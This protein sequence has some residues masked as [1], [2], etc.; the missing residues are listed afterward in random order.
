MKIFT[1]LA[2]VTVNPETGKF[3][4]W[5]SEF[6]QGSAQGIIP[7]IIGLL[8]WAV[9]AISVLMII[10]GGLMYTLSAGDPS[11]T[12]KAKDTIL[13]AVIGLVIALA[14]GAIVTFVRGKFL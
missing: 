10:I 3:T 4:S 2:E 8:L 1:K 7:R 14:A 13:F 6:I 12:K 5:G 11:Q 9:G